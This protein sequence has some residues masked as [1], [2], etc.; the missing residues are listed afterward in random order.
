MLSVRG[1][2]M[3][4]CK[5]IKTLDENKLTIMNLDYGHRSC[6]SQA[7]FLK[8]RLAL[9]LQYHVAVCAA[10]QHILCKF[11]VTSSN[12]FFSFNILYVKQIKGIF[13]IIH[14]LLN[15]LTSAPPFTFPLRRAVLTFSVSACVNYFFQVSRSTWLSLGPFP[16][17]A[18]PLKCID[19][20]WT[21]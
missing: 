10:G 1:W 21:R 11:S 20:N 9:C 6:V 5:R 18:L 13:F 19:Q 14:D 2:H 7:F 16:L 17:A 12:T 8:P 4:C 3:S 15:S